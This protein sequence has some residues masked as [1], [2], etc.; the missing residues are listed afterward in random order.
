[1]VFSTS[2]DYLLYAATFVSHC[3]L[4]SL[5]TI[6]EQPIDMLDIQSSYAPPQKRGN[7]PQLESFDTKYE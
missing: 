4:K 7:H 1:M 5:N 2:D 6:S 3:C